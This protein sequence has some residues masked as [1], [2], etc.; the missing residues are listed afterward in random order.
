MHIENSAAT[1]GVS[2]IFVVSF[3]DWKMSEFN[4]ENPY[5]SEMQCLFALFLT[6]IYIYVI[7]STPTFMI[8]ATEDNKL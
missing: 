1:L 5:K 7:F 2:T 4:F 6:Y 3:T 8:N